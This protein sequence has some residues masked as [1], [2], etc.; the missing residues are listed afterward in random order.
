MQDLQ[1]YQATEGRHETSILGNPFLP[2]V[3]VHSHQLR[4]DTRWLV[5]QTE[6]KKQ[7]YVSELPENNKHKQRA[8]QITMFHSSLGLND[9]PDSLN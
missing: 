7:S 1:K 6:K 2:N 8:L 3:T 4:S 9:K 5:E